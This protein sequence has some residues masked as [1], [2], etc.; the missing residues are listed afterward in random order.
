MGFAFGLN[1]LACFYKQAIKIFW[2][3]VRVDFCPWLD[4][5][6]GGQCRILSHQG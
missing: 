6:P 4:N 3:N 2:Y 1:E 5:Q